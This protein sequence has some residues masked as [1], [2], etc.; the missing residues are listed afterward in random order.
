MTK[1]FT[2]LENYEE[3]GR[4]DVGQHSLAPEPGHGTRRAQLVL[5]KIMKNETSKFILRL[6]SMG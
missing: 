1:P 5:Q 2:G 3:G 6:D 4:G